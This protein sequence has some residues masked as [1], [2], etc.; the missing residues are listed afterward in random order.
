MKTQT[1][2]RKDLVNGMAFAALASFMITVAA[3][4]TLWGYDARQQADAW[5]AKLDQ[6][7]MHQLMDG[8]QITLL[9]P[10]VLK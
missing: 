6:V 5:A 4:N 8:P 7:Q 2:T 3:I 1:Y 10:P 9:P